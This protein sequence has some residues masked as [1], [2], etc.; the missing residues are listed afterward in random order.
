MVLPASCSPRRPLACGHTPDRPLCLLTPPPMCLSGHQPWAAGRSHFTID[1]SVPP[2]RPG[3][4]VWG[5]PG[6]LPW[7]SHLNGPTGICPPVCALGGARFFALHVQGTEGPPPSEGPPGLRGSSGLPRGGPSPCLTAL[8]GVQLSA[9]HNSQIRNTEHW[10]SAGARF[11]SR[12]RRRCW[13]WRAFLGLG[14]DPRRRPGP[15]VDPRA[16]QRHVCARTGQGVPPPAT[17]HSHDPTPWG[18]NRTFSWTQ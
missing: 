17:M 5:P 13:S 4:G 1:N 14:A 16:P 15:Q 6:P 9:F 3:W 2:P 11:S 7:S 12:G 10:A 8:C 18:Q